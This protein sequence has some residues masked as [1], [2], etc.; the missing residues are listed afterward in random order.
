M[1]AY[2]DEHH[3]LIIEPENNVEA[4]ALRF[5]LTIG[6]RNHTINTGNKPSFVMNFVKKVED[7]K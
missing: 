6:V 7:D 4:A 3:D 5:A 2:F 1:K